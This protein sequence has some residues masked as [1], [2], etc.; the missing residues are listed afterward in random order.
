M[1]NATIE[2]LLSWAFVHELP[3]G[4]GVEG[5]AN[6]NSAW[7]QI[8][9]LGVRVD[10]GSTGAQFGGGE[11]NYFIEQGEPHPDALAV[12]EAVRALGSCSYALP[13][14]WN[15]LGDWEDP[16]GL[17]PPAVARVVDGRIAAKDARRRGED[18][19]GLLVSHAILSKV[20]D[21]QADAPKVRMVEVAGKPAWFVSRIFRDATGKD[22]VRE[23]DGYNPKA[24]RPMKDAYRKH[25]F[26][27]DVSGAILSRL[28]W[29]LW[30]AA[31][32][33]LEATLSDRLSAHR[34][35]RIARWV[36]PWSREFRGGAFLVD[37]ADAKKVV[38]AS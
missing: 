10:R 30:V 15:P 24:Q 17:V 21:W 36:S 35:V 18:M 23:L 11:P 37:P 27:D 12:G 38:V 5:L 7:G 20:P 14:D 34:I 22:Y 19:V 33:R 16:H 6:S 31:C 4:G 13:D 25:E 9:E 2:E 3:K 8:C 28:D 1:K 26:S 32:G 29:Q